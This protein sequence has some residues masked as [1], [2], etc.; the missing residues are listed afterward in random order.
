[1]AAG[2]TEVKFACNLKEDHPTSKCR[3]EFVTAKSFIN[4]M[5][6][7]HQTKPWICLQ[8]PG[9]KRFQERQNFNFHMMSHEGRRGFICDFCQKSFANPRQL[10][11]HRALHLGRRYLC[12]HCGFKARSTANL[13]GHIRTKH[14][15]RSFQCLMCEKK[16]STNNNLKNHVSGL[17]M[18]LGSDCSMIS[19]YD[20]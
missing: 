1:M 14:E 3:Q 17:A 20:R 5:K 9:K 12:T 16:F 13:R 19:L 10:Y 8:C 2:A 15:D 6:N 18:F 4:H 11:S 7:T